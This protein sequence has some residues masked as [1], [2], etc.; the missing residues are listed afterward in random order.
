[1]TAVSNTPQDDSTASKEPLATAETNLAAS[2]SDSPIVVFQAHQSGINNIAIS[3]HG[4]LWNCA[5][6]IKS[7]SY[8]QY[9]SFGHC[10][11]CCLICAWFSDDFGAVDEGCYTIATVGDDNAVVV[12]LC[13]LVCL[14]HSS[15]ILAVEHQFSEPS[16]HSSS[17]TG[18]INR[19]SCPVLFVPCTYSVAYMRQN[20]DYSLQVVGIYMWMHCSVF[21]QL[22]M[23]DNLWPLMRL[24]LLRTLSFVSNVLFLPLSL[25]QESSFFI[26][27]HWSLP[28]LIR[29]SM[30]GSWLA[31]H[32]RSRWD[33]YRP[34]F[35]MSLTLQHYSSTTQSK[36][37]ATCI[38]SVLSMIIYGATILLYR[39]NAVLLFC[40]VGF[41]Y[42]CLQCSI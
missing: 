34:T 41:Q 32:Q 30:C 37:L 14:D 1:M 7:Y 13:K 40:G 6:V 36:L 39:D 15:P 25:S 21:F 2:S 31:P 33:W 26:L 12:T 8:G 20:L 24:F 38:Q 16:A 27:I 18:I 17:I 3:S 4:K 5:L 42:Y 35:M 19:R 11:L 29:G 9:I 23:T 28:L 10:M 22:E